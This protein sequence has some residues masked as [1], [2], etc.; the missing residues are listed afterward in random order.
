MAILEFQS[1][2][3]FFIWLWTCSSSPFLKSCHMIILYVCLY[4]IC[5]VFCQP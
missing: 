2:L 5:I 4:H 1:S 3:L